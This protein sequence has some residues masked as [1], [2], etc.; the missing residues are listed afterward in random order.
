MVIDFKQLLGL[1][2]GQIMR[3]KI[4]QLAFIF[5]VFEAPLLQASEILSG[6]DVAD[7]VVGN[8]VQMVFRDARDDFRTRTFHEYYDPDGSIYGSKE[9]SPI[10]LVAGRLKTGN[11]VPLSMAGIIPAIKSDLSTMAGMS[12]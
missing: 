3:V 5:M 2:G 1:V 6:K 7:I 9:I 12:S 11:S 8:T 4:L 10:M